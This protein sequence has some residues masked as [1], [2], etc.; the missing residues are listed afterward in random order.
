MVTKTKY[1]TKLLKK[2]SPIFFFFYNK[3]HLYFETKRDKI[4]SR[5]NVST[6]MLWLI[7]GPKIRYLDILKCI[8][9]TGTFGE[10]KA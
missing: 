5:S 10:K 2:V 9:Q 8:E 6:H 3:L 1:Y 7:Y 4:N